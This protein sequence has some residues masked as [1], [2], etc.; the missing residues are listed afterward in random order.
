MKSTFYE[1]QQYIHRLTDEYT[2]A[3]DEGKVSYPV[4]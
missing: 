3:T 1:R 4:L 2:G